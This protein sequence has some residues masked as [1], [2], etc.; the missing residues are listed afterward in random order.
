[1]T[2]SVRGKDNVMTRKVR[3][4]EKEKKGE[5]KESKKDGQGK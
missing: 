5:G 4:K 3:R 2:R 1:M